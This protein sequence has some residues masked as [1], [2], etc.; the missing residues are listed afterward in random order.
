VDFAPEIDHAPELLAALLRLGILPCIGHSDAAYE[1]ALAAI[2]AGVRHCTHLFNAM[3]PLRHRAPG[4]AGALLSDARATVEIIADG[5]HVHPA[6]LR[7]VVAARGAGAVALVT[8]AL[9]AAGLPADASTFGGRPVSV[10][11]GAAYLADG[12]LAGSVL[13]LD[14]AVRNMVDLAGA[15]WSEAIRMATLTPARIAGVADR[16][17]GLA[18]GLDADLVVLDEAGNVRQTWRAGERVFEHTGV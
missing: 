18:V 15:A 13:T 4:V 12:T 8:D 2:D 5:V 3:P 1:Q 11:D 14:Q 6:V 9:S 10:R 17:G 7:I 16:K